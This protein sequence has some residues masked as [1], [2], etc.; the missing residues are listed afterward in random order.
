MPWIYKITRSVKIDFTL[1]DDA[2]A[3]RVI[4]HGAGFLV[5]VQVLQTLVHVVRVEENR[6]R[7][8]AAVRRV[9]T[10]QGFNISF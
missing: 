4:L 2:P 8:T 6:L 7:Q 9:L 1:A 3:E 10:N 5:I